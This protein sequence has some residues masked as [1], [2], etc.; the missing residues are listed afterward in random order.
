MSSDTPRYTPYD[1]GR[2][3][4]TLGIR[5]IDPA[6]WIEV[7]GHYAAHLAEKRRLFAEC[8]AEVFDAIDGSLSAQTECLELLLDN[9]AR[10]LPGTVEQDDRTVRVDQTG[11]HYDREAFAARPL[12]FGRRAGQRNGTRANHRRL[13]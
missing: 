9:L 7:D 2:F 1:K 13:Q 4:F 3:Q 11:D 8:P 12:P 6:E 10:N 5:A